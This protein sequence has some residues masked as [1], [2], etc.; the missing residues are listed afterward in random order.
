MNT[1]QTQSFNTFLYIKI[2]KPYNNKTEEQKIRKKQ[3]IDEIIASL[4]EMKKYK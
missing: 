4:E 1:Q 2:E 3:N